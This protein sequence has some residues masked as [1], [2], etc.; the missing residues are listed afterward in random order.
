MATTPSLTSWLLAN[1]EC[2]DLRVS[3]LDW[4]SEWLP[5]H[6]DFAV[7]MTMDGQLFEGRGTAE[8]E[9]LA[10]AKAGG[11]ALERIAAASVNAP[12][13]SGFALHPDVTLASVLAKAELIERD[14]YFCHWLTRTPFLGI[15]P[16]AVG[17][18]TIGQITVSAIVARLSRLGIDLSYARLITADGTAAI[19]CVARGIRALRRPFGVV[20]GFGCDA[21]LQAAIGKATVECLRTVVAWIHGTYQGGGS[22]TRNSFAAIRQPG[23]LE[24]ERLGLSVESASLLDAYLAPS[25]TSEPRPYEVALACEQ[26][27]LPAS[28]ADAPVVVMRAISAHLQ[29]AIFGHHNSTDIN[30]ARLSQFVGRVIAPSD[31]RLYPHAFG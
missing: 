22:L 23:P 1:A 20:Q 7:Q 25:G 12:S 2:L 17:S 26:V 9:D 31:V 21:T 30:F 24:H 14:A 8:S 3:Q 13:T 28:I 18:V 10:F 11:E 6:V 16:E 27:P 15:D 19:I 5:G 29:P 4:V